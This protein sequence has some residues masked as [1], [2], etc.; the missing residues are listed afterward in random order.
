MLTL[1]SPAALDRSEECYDLLDSWHVRIADIEEAA[2]R[3][4][5]RELLF[6]VTSRCAAAQKEIKQCRQEL[7]WLKQV[8]DH[9]ELV[10]N[11]FLSWRQ[12]LWAAID[13]DQMLMHASKLQKEVKLLVKQ[14]R[15]WPVYKQ[16]AQTLADMLVALPLTYE[17]CRVSP[18]YSVGFLLLL[19]I[20]FSI[21]CSSTS[22]NSIWSA[23]ALIMTSINIL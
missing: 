17:A 6:D 4:H 19:S 13:V 7:L 9:V 1:T 20:R 23:F 21:A 11:V 3:L 15:S 8:W 12:T 2:E 14:S 10:E 16:L 5:Q 22:K 18:R